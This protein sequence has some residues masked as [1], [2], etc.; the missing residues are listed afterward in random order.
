MHTG[1][2][3][4]SIADARKRLLHSGWCD[5]CNKLLLPT[6]EDARIYVGLIL[7]HRS[8]QPVTFALTPYRC[9]HS[10]RR[11]HVG[12][13]TNTLRLDFAAGRVKARQHE[14]AL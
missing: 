13:N 4:T 6:E 14:H 11:W 7:T 9:P 3:F 5:R 2:S 10:P 12:R 8:L 1:L